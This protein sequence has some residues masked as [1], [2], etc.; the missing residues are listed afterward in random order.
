M[1]DKSR[2]SE[3]V[4][5]KKKVRDVLERDVYIVLGEAE[6]SLI[7]HQVPPL[8]EHENYLQ[9]IGEGARCSDKS[10]ASLGASCLPASVKSLWE[11]NS[12][13]TFIS[14]LSAFTLNSVASLSPLRNRVMAQRQKEV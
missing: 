2:E 1:R 7:N 5:S 14:S 3:F 8:A 10:D 9:V 13:S 12:R 11:N 6:I 4:K